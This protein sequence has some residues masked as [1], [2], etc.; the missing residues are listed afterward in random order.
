LIE[1]NFKSCKQISLKISLDFRKETGWL[2]KIIQFQMQFA[3]AQAGFFSSE[4]T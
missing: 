3:Q 4:S 2:E 1:S